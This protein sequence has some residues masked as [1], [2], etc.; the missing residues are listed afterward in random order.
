MLHSLIRRTF[1]ALLV[2][3]APVSNAFSEDISYDYIQATFALTTVNVG[4][5]ASKADGTGF[6]LALSLSTNKYL[7][8]TLSVLS[9]TFDKFQGLEV[10][11][12]KLTTYGFTAHTSIAPATDVYTNLSLAKAAATVPDGSTTEG[13]TDFGSRFSVGL[14]YLAT[15]DIE[16]EIA[17]SNTD[18]F[19]TTVFSYDFE[20]RLYFRKVYSLTLGY[21]SS[22]NSDS[23]QLLIRMDI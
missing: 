23:F 5:S 6:G 16:L 11:N 8:F 2:I 9:T 18:V 12:A 4:E 14:R 20:T 22:D 19:D 3:L 13:G 7:A 21:V 15:D 1:L 10:D 17:G